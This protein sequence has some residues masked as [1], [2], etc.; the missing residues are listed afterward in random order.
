MPRPLKAVVLERVSRTYGTTVALRDVSARFDAG[1]ITV[2]RGPNGSGKSTTLGLLSTAQRPSSGRVIWDPIGDDPEAIRPHLGWLGHDALV[3]PDLSGEENLLWVG[4]VLGVSEP[5]VR[6]AMKRVGIGGF[7]QRSVRTMSRGQR[8]RVALA[9]AI[10]AKPSLLLLD[11]PTT[12][13]DV[14]G[15]ALLTTIVKQEVD[16]GA[17]VVLVTHE[18]AL[19]EQLG[20]RELRL[21]RGRVVTQANAP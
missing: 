3:Y 11:E 16:A 8:Q 1:T 19:K 21:E 2:L 12:G 17:I 10:L 4:R 15:V 5:D 9:R 20:A 7:G 14:E 13:L 18:P 6:D